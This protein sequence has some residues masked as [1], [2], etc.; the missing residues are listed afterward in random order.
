MTDK[1][2]ESLDGF[3]QEMR[4]D[5]FATLRRQCERLE[6]ALLA[7]RADPTLRAQACEIL[8]K[9]VVQR[10]AMG[11]RSHD[12]LYRVYSVPRDVIAFMGPA[13]VASRHTSG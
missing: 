11:L 1:R 2:Q 6:A 8:W 10:E 13:D 12:E 9:I 5:G 3:V 4:A 7:Y